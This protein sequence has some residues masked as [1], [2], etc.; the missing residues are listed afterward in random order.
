MRADSAKG[1]YVN[2]ASCPSGFITVPCYNK[3]WEIGFKKNWTGGNL[4]IRFIQDMAKYV[5]I[6]SPNF[7][8]ISHTITDAYS[9]KL[10]KASI[11]RNMLRIIAL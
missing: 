3:Q 2:V 9:I 1:Y 5:Q 10:L 4:N 11:Q 7:I 6:S 8:N